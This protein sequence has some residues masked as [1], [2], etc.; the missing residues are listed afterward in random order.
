MEARELEN[1]LR[2]MKEHHPDR[3]AGLSEAEQTQAEE[4][5]KEINRAYAQMLGKA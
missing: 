4:R 3:V 5:S 2:L 1:W